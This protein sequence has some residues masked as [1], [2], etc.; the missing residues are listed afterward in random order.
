MEASNQNWKTLETLTD[1]Y[2]FLV[3]Y[4]RYEISNTLIDILDDN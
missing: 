3:W 1:K 4:L 2:E